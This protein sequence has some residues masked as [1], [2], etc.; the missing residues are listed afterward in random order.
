MPCESEVNAVFIQQ[1]MRVAQADQE[2]IIKQRLRHLVCSY[3]LVSS[4]EHEEVQAPI[5][6]TLTVLV[7]SI[8]S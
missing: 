7:L 6:F 4:S 8:F 3:S 1:T 2:L 5:G